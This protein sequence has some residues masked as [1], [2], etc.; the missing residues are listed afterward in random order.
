MKKKKQHYSEIQILNWFTQMCLALKH[1]HDRK[2]LHRDLKSQ[3]IF[4]T[5]NGLIKMGDF[6]I[7]RIA[8]GQQTTTGVV[9]ATLNHAA[10]ELLDGDPPTVASD[11]YGVGTF[12]ARFRHVFDTFSTLFGHFL[13]IS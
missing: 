13:D 2:I 5:K 1:C 11:V 6:G 7:A 12:S 8:G 4:M 3:N 10:P 9:T